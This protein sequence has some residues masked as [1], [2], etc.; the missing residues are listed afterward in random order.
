MKKLSQLFPIA[1]LAIVTA[2]IFSSCK[3]SDPEDHN[4]QESFTTVKLV[5]TNTADAS[6]KPE[7]TIK[8]KEGFGHGGDLLEKNETIK[9]KADASYTVE[10]IL[11]DESKT[12][13]EVM[14]EEVEEEGEAH[15]I[16]YQ[17]SGASLTVTYADID[18]NNRPIGLKTTQ[19]TGSAGS[20][21]LKVTLKHQQEGSVYLK[22]DTSDVNTGE[23]DVEVTFSVVIE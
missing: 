2:S 7:A 12:P 20:A 19:T 3:V 17:A 21:T 5:Y 4:E 6:D 14:S 8:F 16:F 23:T 1:M 13:A 11:L 22:N 10:L 15:Q 9:L 18:G